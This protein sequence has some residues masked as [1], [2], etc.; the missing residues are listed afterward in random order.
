MNRFDA[1]QICLYFS[2]IVLLFFTT[3][4]FCNPGPFDE[5][6]FRRAHVGISLLDLETGEE[7]YAYNTESYFIPASLQKVIISAA[8]L[9]LLGEEYRF[10]TKVEYEGALDEQGTLKGDLFIRGGGDPTLSLDVIS[11]WEQAV[12]EAGIRR[13][14]GKIIAEVGCYE[15]LQAS[16]YWEFGDLGNYYGAGASAL[17]INQN[18]YKVTFRPGKAEGEPA[19]VIQI[20]PPIPYL[21]YRNEVTTG[22]QG[23]GD[24][25]YVFGSEYSFDQFYR[26]TVPIDQ[27]T[28]TIKAA[29]PDPALFCAE[30]LAQK[31]SATEGVFTSHDRFASTR[32]EI[33]SLKSPSLVEIIKEMN[34]YSINLYAEHLL[35]TIGKGNSAKGAKGV[36]EFLKERSI[37]AR[38]RDGAGI[39]RNNLITPSGMTQL[40]ALIHKSSDCKTIYTSFP[41][42]GKSGTLQNFPALP[43]ATLRAKTGSMSQIYNLAGYLTFPSGKE[44]AFAIFIN[45]HECSIAT[46]YK[47]FH[48]F[49]ASYGQKE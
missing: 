39:A 49:L 27:P 32:Q 26:G 17:S 36:E 29:I 30:L 1:A 14:E 46:L 44:Y 10:Q 4:G 2:R 13:V 48:C 6:G 47:A 43:E 28:L 24:C 8:A 5:E 18:L 35:K 11:K 31:V 41:E 40:L 45:N 23:S 34:T 12:Q 42:P 37:P 15:T 19:E 20:D 3:C 21:R 25:V 16:P 38:V 7:V 33:F 22:P 9:S